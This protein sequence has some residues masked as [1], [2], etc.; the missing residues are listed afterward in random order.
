VT[1]EHTCKERV[2]GRYAFK[3][4]SCGKKAK[5]EHEGHWYCKT[6]HPPTVVERDK[7]RKARWEKEWAAAR[8]KVTQKAEQ[9]RRADLYPELL[10]A[11]KLAQSIIG[12]PEDAHSKLISAAIAK[13]E[14][15]KP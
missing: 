7:A 10:E 3:S 5:H 13:A 14:E 9:Q 2:W 11:L 1:T 6:H 4:N 15:V 12:H 8:E